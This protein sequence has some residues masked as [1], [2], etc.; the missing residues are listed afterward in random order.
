MFFQWLIS[1]TLG[2]LSGIF[3]G[4]IPG[5]HINLLAALI[6][7]A[8][9][10]KIFPIE[11]LLIYIVALSITHTFLD[12]IPSIYLG[13]PSEDTI[14]TTLIGH[15]YLMKGKAHA[16]LDLTNKGSL[17]AIFSILLVFPFLY[18]ILPK[19]YL[20]I[21]KIIPLVLI[22]VIG[23]IIFSENK[24][25]MKTFLIILLAGFLG[26]VCLNIEINQPLLP[27]LTG[28]FSTSTLFY[29]I[30]NKTTPP[31]QELGT[32][33]LPKRNFIKPTLITTLVSPFFSLLPGLGS[34]QAAIISQKIFRNKTEKQYL[35][36]LGSINTLVIST[37]FLTL[38]LLNKTRTGAAAAIKQLT[39]ITLP[40]MKFIFLVILVTGI[41][42]YFITKI[43]SKKV[44]KN[45]EKLNYQKIS[46]VVIF[47]TTVIVILVSGFIGLLIL[48]TSTALGIFCQELGQRK[49]TLMASIMIPTIIYYLI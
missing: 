7:E 44:A 27:L 41:F 17:I 18:W 45:L 46:C 40:Q 5:L 21:Q 30:K 4:L 39:E 20:F 42:A 15:K 31:K 24:T 28:L 33:Q 3:T 9:F 19:S 35:I 47:L 12:F 22:W 1:L 48:I 49:S 38:Y 10:I 6:V 43:I 26:I 37:S 11:I 36:L 16:A 2:I 25:R 23:I 13:A 29:S 32:F 8:V 14:A 34:S